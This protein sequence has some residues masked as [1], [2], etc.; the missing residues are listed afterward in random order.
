MKTTAVDFVLSRLENV[1]QNGHGA[2]A[3]CPAHDDRRNSLSVS[4]GDDGRVLLRCHA[5][6]GCTPEGIV[7]AIGLTMADLFETQNGL[8][9]QQ[10]H[11]VA[12]YDYRAGTELLYQ[13][14]RYKPKDFRLRCPDGRGG[15]IW[16]LKGVARVLYR[17]PE[18][19]AADTTTVV[20][21]PEG[22][23]DVEAL[24]RLGLVATC[25]VGGAG[26]WQPAYSEA[27]RG[28]QVVILPDHDE[29]GRKHALL[30][31]RS[32]EGIAASVKVLE[33]PDLPE[34]GDVTDWLGAV[35][36]A[37]QL[38]AL[39]AEAPFFASFALL[40]ETG[41]AA[42]V[43][44]AVVAPAAFPLDVLPIP[45]RVYVQAAAEALGAPSEMIAVPLLAYAG[46]TIGSG[47][48][49]ELKPGYWQR[50]IIYAAV[51][52]PP[53]SMK[54]PAQDAARYPLD[55]LQR[56]AIERYKE[57]LKG[58]E[59]EL[60]A[61]QSAPKE[62]REEKPEKPELEHY[63]T[64]DA[65]LEALAVIL[66]RSAGV[67]LSRDEVVGWV[68]SC[69]AY[70]GGR[71]GDRQQWLSLWA[72]SP[73]KVDR[74]KGEPVYVPFPTV[75]VVGG[76]QPELLTDLADEAGRRDGFIERILW[77]CPDVAPAGWTEQSVSE[78]VQAGL[79]DLFRKLRGASGDPVRLSPE[80]RDEWARWFNENAHL[81][82]EASG[83]AQGIYAKLPN[84]AARLALILHCLNFP[85]Q[86]AR[87]PLSRATLL[88]AIELTEYFRSHA[89]RVLP[90]FGATPRSRNA[91]LAG[92]VL[93]ILTDAGGEWVERAALHRKLSGHV[94]KDELSTALED[95]ASRGLSE[96]RSMPTGGRPSE[97]WRALHLSEES[98]KSEQSEETQAQ[99]G[100]EGLSSLSSFVRNTSGGGEQ[101]GAGKPLLDGGPPLIDPYRR[102]QPGEELPF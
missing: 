11:I 75:C 42:E 81:T 38:L 96:S 44:G 100:Q 25:N 22:E 46:A 102:V 16:N 74:K 28:R 76:V 56:E 7:Q 52:A 34:H 64:T 65:T 29:A 94:G 98:E 35:G 41:A 79:L 49:I 26:K 92:R 50:P 10:R 60:E 1:R 8:T 40:A 57:E 12:T 21:I 80:A 13:T 99:A 30:V 47:Q 37:D 88:S 58:Y 39:A 9:P 54:T 84:Q 24:C 31:G 51:V 72:G 23:K 55:V 43:A 97:Q 83:L 62:T 95:L 3:R 87:R 18:L 5:N 101:N 14:V 69:D 67:V 78:T 17:L 86:A 82:A 85:A 20:F 2:D 53:G 59:R 48:R 77:S 19:Q 66:A 90:R 71:G 32:L 63:F 93:R 33:L 61:W 45:V 15:W 27:L 73:L 89:L 36:D 4:S 70:R 91:G 68:K 6:N